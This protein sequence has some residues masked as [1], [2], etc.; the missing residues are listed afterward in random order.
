[1]GHVAGITVDGSQRA[2]AIGSEGGINL[3][4]MPMR[5]SSDSTA[6]RSD[7][8]SIIQIKRYPTALIDIWRLRDGTRITLRPV[9]PKTALCWET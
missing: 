5:R 7:A 9:L 4:P 3:P 2:R 8:R 1:M 6:A